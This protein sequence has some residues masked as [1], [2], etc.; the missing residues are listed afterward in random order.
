[1]PNDSCTLQTDQARNEYHSGKQAEYL[2][3]VAERKVCHACAP[4]LT[5][6]SVIE[7]G[8]LDSEHIGPHSRWQGNLDAELVVVAQDF[9]DD[10][11][12]VRVRGW[13]G[14]KVQTNRRLVELVAAAGITIVAPKRG[15]CD[16]RLFFTNAVL[17]LKRG[18]ERLSNV[19]DG[20]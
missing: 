17:C 7:G 4:E 2:K 15:C 6:P 5:N 14:E 11:T 10:K 1:M 19:V 9:A 8:A 16:D 12:F 13:P 18:G 20:A 3:L